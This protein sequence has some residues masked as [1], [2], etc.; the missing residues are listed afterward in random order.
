MLVLHRLHV[1]I[2]CI[3]CCN[4]VFCASGEYQ[5][6]C[7]LVRSH[8]EAGSLLLFTVSCVGLLSLPFGGWRIPS[9]GH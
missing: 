8:F 2:I 4:P 5:S 9:Q 1:V 3:M 6:D 7:L